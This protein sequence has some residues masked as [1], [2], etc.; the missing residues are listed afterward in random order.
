MI[1]YRIAKKKYIKDLSGI[2]ARL[3]EGRWNHKGINIIYTSESRAL[4]TVEYLVHVPL[5]IVPTNISIAT[6]EI[7]DGIIPKEI[8]TS[9]LPNNWQNYPWPP[10]LPDLGTNWAL[11]NDTLLLRVPS[12]VVEHEFNVLIN[13]SHPDIKHVSI[14]NIEK[15]KFDARLL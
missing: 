6:F 13:P 11:K 8:S 1:V 5:S 9:N 4:A 12:T 3:Y 7:P 2:G 14:S 10:E 15:Y